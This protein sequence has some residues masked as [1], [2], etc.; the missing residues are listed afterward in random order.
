LTPP[1]PGVRLASIFYFQDLPLKVYR[2]TFR[3]LA[4]VK[5]VLATGRPSFGKSP[6]EEVVD[7]L[8]RG[9]H[10]AW[11]GIFLASGEAAPQYLLCGGAEDPPHGSVQAAATQ[12]GATQA[13]P[14]QVMLPETRSKILISLKLASRELG[15]LSVESDREN[16]FGSEDRVLLEGVADAVARFLTGRGKYLARRARQQATDSQPAPQA[17]V[18]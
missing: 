4:D 8:C 11:A 3:L 2:P 13:G 7:L 17:R 6:L 16:A 18:A 15:V 12:A 1:I 10:Y 9:R 14:A 5:R